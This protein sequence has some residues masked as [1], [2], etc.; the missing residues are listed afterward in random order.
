[1]YALFDLKTQKCVWINSV[2]LNINRLNDYQ[3][4]TAKVMAI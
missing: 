2:L 1:M 3:L 4:F